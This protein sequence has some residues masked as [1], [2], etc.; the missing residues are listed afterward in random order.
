MCR[1]FI[2]TLFILTFALAANVMY[3]YAHQL[4]NSHIKSN[5]TPAFASKIH[6]GV[7]LDVF[8]LQAEAYLAAINA[9]SILGDEAFILYKPIPKASPPSEQSEIDY[10]LYKRRRLDE[11]QGLLYIS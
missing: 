6:K 11:S 7:Y 1:F 4:G 2:K 10:Q 5:S 9:L 8:K 3:T